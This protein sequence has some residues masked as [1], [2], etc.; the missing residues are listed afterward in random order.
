VLGRLRAGGDYVVLGPRAFLSAAEP[1]LEQRRSQGLEPV[2]VAIEDVYDEFGAGEARPAAVRAFLEDAFQRWTR[3]PRHVLLLGDASYDFKDALRTGAPNHVPPYTIRD[4]YLWTVSDPTYA[5]VNGEDAL[6]D[7]AIG[8]LPARTV[9]EAHAL[10]E[11]VLAWENARLD[12]SGRSV[13][14]ADNSDAAGDFEADS[15][16][17]ARTLLAGR[18]IDRIYL[19]REG[20]ATRARVAQAF[21]AGASLMSYLGHGGVAVWASENVWNN[22]DVAALAPQP[23]QPV[24]LAMDCLNGYFHHPS[25][26]AL[27]EELLKAEGRGV[28]AAIAPSSLSVHWAARLYHAALVRELASGRHER[29]GDVL[30]AAQAA[31]LEAGARPDLLR[32]FQLLGDPALRI[33]Q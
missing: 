22:W 20:G 11:K 26:N 10:V 23:E 30:L 9:A 1:L 8:R 27:A 13:L 31:Y 32:T 29:L 25:M 33:R 21:D 14:V 4:A 3:T 24:L 16:T 28:I 15:E 17:V 5:M 19:S 6:P 7:F 2:A 18:E 12:L